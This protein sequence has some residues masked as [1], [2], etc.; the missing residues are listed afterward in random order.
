MCERRKQKPRPPPFL[1]IPNPTSSDRTL[2]FHRIFSDPSR[3]GIHSPRAPTHARIGVHKHCETLTC[4]RQHLLLSHPPPIPL[5]PLHP[6]SA[7]AAMGVRAAS[8]SSA[9]ASASREAAAAATARQ[10]A[11]AAAIAP[12][13]PPTPSPAARRYALV[14]LA[15]SSWGP[16]PLFEGGCYTLPL[17][18]RAA[19]SSSSPQGRLVKFERVLVVRDGRGGAAAALRSPVPSPSGRRNNNNNA[20][21]AGA[22]V[23]AELVEELPAS[24]LFGGSLSRVRVTRIVAPSDG[25]V[26][27]ATGAAS[28][29]SSR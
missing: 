5:F 4:S 17:E 12:P 10:R 8:S 28:A 3:P 23:E 19:S 15:S 26:K 6:M 29:A 24:P 18:Q 13:A 16:A 2:S 25:E 9:S 1:L 14:D 20:Y 7:T 11:T 21:V 27:E 22:W